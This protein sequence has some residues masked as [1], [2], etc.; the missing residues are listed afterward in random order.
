MFSYFAAFG[1]G[2]LESILGHYADDG[3]FLPP[4]GETVTGHDALRAS[5]VETLRRIRI[6]P[7][8]QSS[9]E[10]VV[11]LGDFAWV[12]TDSRASV[13]NLETGETSPGRFREVFLLRRVANDWKIWRYTFNTIAVPG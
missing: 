9:A 11:Q 4:G 6:V 13:R 12:R 2:D 3:M 5:Y 7:G 8:G 10:D 1:A